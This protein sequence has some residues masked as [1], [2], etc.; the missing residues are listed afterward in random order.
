MQVSCGETRIA[1]PYC[2][3]TLTVS[4][5]IDDLLDRMTL[6]EKIGCITTGGA[7]G[8]TVPRLGIEMTWA[9]SLH[10]LRWVHADTTFY[11]SRRYASSRV[12]V[13]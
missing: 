3:P 9:E 5:R 2:D 10:G 8:C 7:A 11:S 12:C 1:E 4:D 6:E 13:L